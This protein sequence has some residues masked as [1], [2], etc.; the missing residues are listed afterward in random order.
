MVR[1]LFPMNPYSGGKMDLIDNQKERDIYDKYTAEILK[2]DYVHCP[3]D[4]PEEL[5]K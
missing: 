4:T 2:T 5:E 3:F 1:V